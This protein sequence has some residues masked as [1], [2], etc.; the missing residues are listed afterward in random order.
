[1]IELK[2]YERNPILKPLKD[3]NWENVSVFNPAVLQIEGK[4]YLIYRALS[5]TFESSLGLA[6]SSDGYTI[7]ER[8]ESPCYF[9][10]MAYETKVKPTRK[11]T[12]CEDPRATIIGDRIY[13]CYTA[14][15]QRERNVRIALTS[16]SI[17]DFLERNWQAWEKPR[18]ISPPGF[19]DKNGLVLEERIN[20]KYCF[21]HR[22]MFKKMCIWV[23]FV[24]SL[25]LEKEG[26]IMGWDYIHPR[27][28]KWDKDWVGTCG[29]PIK[30]SEGWVMIYHG[31]GNG[32]Y[33]LGAMLLAKEN[34]AHV[35]SRL[36]YPILRP[37]KDYE[38]YGLSNNVVYSCGNVVID[39]TL[40]VYYGA[41]DT[42]IAVATCDL[43]ELISEL[44]KY[45]DC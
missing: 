36:D 22:P 35:I 6:I 30:V 19:W 39:D 2:R 9:P 41:A 13:M 44:L 37:E 12:G 16:I 40:F 20:G 26:Y 29:P 25:G 43:N 8:L 38:K 14:V 42:T 31:H 32:M 15:G 10:R 18:L 28:D 17:K 34:P 45:A 11:Y 33:M 21:F 4:I 1:M 3:H 24:E 27:P 7:E 23:D 5:T